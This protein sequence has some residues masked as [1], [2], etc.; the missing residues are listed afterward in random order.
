MY[1]SQHLLYL[2]GSKMFRLYKKDVPKL[3]PCVKGGVPFVV[4]LLCNHDHTMTAMNLK[5]K[6]KLNPLKFR[7]QT[8]PT[9]LRMVPKVPWIEIKN[10]KH[11]F[12]FDKSSI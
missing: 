10:A 5:Q 4:N 6:F 3:K 2:R 1:Y 12:L 7:S 8:A 9:T 11:M